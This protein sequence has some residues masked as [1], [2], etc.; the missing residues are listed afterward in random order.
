[1]SCT[2]P[3]R[4]GTETT[5]LV[6][7]WPDAFGGGCASGVGDDGEAGAVVRVVL[8][9]RGDDVQAELAR[10]ALA[11]DA[12]Q[13]VV[14]AG[15]ARAFGVARDRPAFGVGQVVAEPGMALRERL[16]MGAD[17]VDAV[18]RIDAAQQV[19]PHVAGWSRRR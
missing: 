7:S 19:V 9:R 5:R 11:G 15:Q 17:G 13:R 8:D 10:R 1:M 4:F 12:G 3:G 18:E 14:E 2:A 6:Q 16:R